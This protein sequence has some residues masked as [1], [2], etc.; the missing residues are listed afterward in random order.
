MISSTLA[1]TTLPPRGLLNEGRQ[2]GTGTKQPTVA[3]VGPPKPSPQTPSFVHQQS[4]WST[5]TR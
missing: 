3:H 1:T 5:W 4:L 2:R